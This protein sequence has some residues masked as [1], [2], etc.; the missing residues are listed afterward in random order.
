MRA[1]AEGLVGIA[2]RQAQRPARR[3]PRFKKKT[4]AVPSFRLRNRHPRGGRPA[5][6]VGDNG[7]SRSIT[8]PGIGQIAVHDDT[9]RLR[10][11][12]AKGRA[13]IRLETVSHDADRWWVSINVEAADLHVAHRHVPRGEARHSDWVGIDRPLIGIP[14]R[15]HQRRHRSRP[16][17]RWAEGTRRRDATPAAAGEVIV[18]QEERITPPPQGRRKARTSP[19]PRRE[20]ASTLLAP[21]IESVGQDPRPTRYREPER[22]RYAA[23][24]QPRP[25]DLGCGMGRIR[26][27]TG[28]QA[29]VAKRRTYHRRPLVPIEQAVLGM[30]SQQHRAVAHRSGLH[31]RLRLG[32]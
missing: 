23:Q 8:L 26:P 21:G 30:R 16:H 29:A 2:L 14:G 11:M 13:K 15:C 22:G 1:G 25:S 17:L 31:V 4:A 10:R 12:L 32:S 9:R 20:R 24:L 28:L 18:P 27:S 5:I 6:R 19:P 7:R 3:V